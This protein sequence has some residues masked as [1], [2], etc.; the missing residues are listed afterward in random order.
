MTCGMN[1]DKP[2]GKWIET[3]RNTWFRCYKSRDCLYFRGPDDTVLQHFR[4]TETSGFYKYEKDVKTLP[5]AC[6]PVPHRVVGESI[7][8]RRP[9]SMQHRHDPPAV[10]PG[11]VVGNTLSDSTS[12]TLTLASDGS[13][14]IVGE[15]AA[16]AWVVSAG[17]GEELQ[18]VVLLAGMSSLSAYRTELEGE[19][20]CLKHVEYLDI[21][22]SEIEQWCDNERAVI[23]AAEP[24]WSPSGMVG[25]HT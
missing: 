5:T 20:R 8:S 25:G 11:H 21:P 9:Y 17:E 2:L 4:H 15:A 24:I 14:H 13:V 10:P 18:A 7:W 3:E 22:V 6:H 1:L 16:A 12:E 23:A 19:F